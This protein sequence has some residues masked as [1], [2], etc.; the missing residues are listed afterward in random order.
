MVDKGAAVASE[1]KHRRQML[2]TRRPPGY[3]IPEMVTL[4]TAASEKPTPKTGLARTQAA[5]DIGAIAGAVRRYP[6]RWLAEDMSYSERETAC[7]A[8]R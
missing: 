2:C 4:V 6:I 7:E 1:P 8:W 3:M 5:Y